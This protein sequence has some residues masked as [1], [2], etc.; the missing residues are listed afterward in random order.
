[1][2][3]LVIGISLGAALVGS[4]L[5][6]PPPSVEAAI[7]AYAADDLPTAA[8]GFTRF[9]QQGSALA[10]YNLA[11]MHLRNELPQANAATAHHLLLRAARQHFVRAE[12]ALG[13]FY[14]QGRQHRSGMPDLQ[15]AVHW[16]A[17][18][19]EHGSVDAQVAMGTAF[20]LGRGAKQDP[21]QAALWFRQAATGGDVGAQYLLASMYENGLGVDQDL[22][23]AR[24]WYAA[25]AANGDE[26]APF[27][28]KELDA[29]LIQEPAL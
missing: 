14:E 8:Q 29:R 16:Y 18:A 26:A 3:R 21:Q 6:G 25:A 19:A 11:M 24:Y 15:Q 22:R 13:E 20:Y 23:L 9:A 5:A 4:A 17:L 27:K 12:L 2:Q 1:M 7:A 28:V 10:Q